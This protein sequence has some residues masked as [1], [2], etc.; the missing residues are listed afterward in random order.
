MQKESLNDVEKDA[1]QWVLQVLEGQNPFA[2]VKE[3]NIHDM[4]QI[5]YALYQ[6][7]EYL[8]ANH[9]FK[10]LVMARPLEAKYW[11]G[12]GAC[13]Q[14]QKDYEKA[15]DCY[16]SAQTFN[17]IKQD[18]YLYVYVADCYFALTQAEKGLM[19]LESARLLA[20]KMHDQRILNHVTLMQELWSK[21]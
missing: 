14:M 6:N 13:L 11:K 17:E 20:E 3:E 18:P 4:Y 8:K 2:Q 16:M 12:F 15:I 19:A 1:A 7:Q 21:K 5:G 10:L 9:F